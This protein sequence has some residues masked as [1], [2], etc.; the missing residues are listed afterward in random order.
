MTLAQS[1]A[2]RH[3]LH[4]SRARDRTEDRLFENLAKIKAI[5]T[6]ARTATIRRKAER[7]RQAAQGARE[8]GL[9]RPE[10]PSA[11]ARPVPE[12]NCLAPAWGRQRRCSF[13]RR[14][15]TM[16]GDA[17]ALHLDAAAR[18][19]LMLDDAQRIACIDRDLWIG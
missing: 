19:L 13:H 12:P 7:S 1:E 16:T 14:R 2:S 9:A 4:A 5:E 8:A 17:D 3:A 10:T 6:A 11:S 15:T 18:R